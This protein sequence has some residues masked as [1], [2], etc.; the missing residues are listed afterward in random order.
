MN[1]DQFFNP[2]GPMAFTITIG[3]TAMKRFEVTFNTVKHDETEGEIIRTV[4]E[5]DKTRAIKQAL[6]EIKGFNDVGQYKSIVFAK[7]AEVS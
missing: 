6:A 7:A 1:P 2:V 4:A 5:T 3:V